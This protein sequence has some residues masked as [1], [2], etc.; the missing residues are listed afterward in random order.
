MVR[1]E[2][3]IIGS[4]ITRYVDSKL[5]RSVLQCRERDVLQPCQRVGV[6]AAHETDDMQGHWHSFGRR[7]VKGPNVKWA[8]KSVYILTASGV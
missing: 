5:S 7:L 6:D 3:L 2:P 1:S 8:H 4:T